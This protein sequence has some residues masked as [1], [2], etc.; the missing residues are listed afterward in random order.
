MNNQYS[1][2]MN[3]NKIIRTPFIIESLVRLFWNLRHGSVALTLQNL[4]R[5][6]T[7]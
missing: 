4:G 6:N 1:V 5:G 3:N 2:D 7:I